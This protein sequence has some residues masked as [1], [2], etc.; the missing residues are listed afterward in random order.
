MNKVLLTFFLVLFCLERAHAQEWELVKSEDGIEIFNREVQ[1]SDFKEFKSVSEIE[2]DISAF[3]ALILD[4]EGMTDWGYKLK[5]TELLKREGDSLQIYFAEASAPFP[6]KNRFGIYLNEFKWDKGSKV[7]TIDIKLLEDYPYDSGDLVML[8]GTSKWSVR[9]LGQDRIE[10]T[11]QMLID[12]GKG[13]PAWLSNMVSDESPLQTMLS[14][15]SEIGKP[16]YQ[17]QSFDFLDN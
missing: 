7:L 6:Y 8:K 16:K 3:T 1:G 14:I 4:V 15:R 11:F 9:E 17:N 12:P 5:R 2:G 13:I 10:V